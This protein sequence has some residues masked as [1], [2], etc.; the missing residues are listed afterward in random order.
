MTALV[1]VAGLFATGMAAWSV[2]GFVDRAETVEASTAAEHATAAVRLVLDRAAAMVR[3]VR[4]MYATGEVTDDQF[5]RFARTLTANQGVAALGFI[6]RIDDKDRAQYETRL[7]SSPAAALGVWQLGDNGTP[8]QAPQRPSYLVLEANLTLSGPPPAL[9]FD[10]ESLPDRASD[11]HRALQRFQLTTTDEITLPALNEVGITLYDPAVD[12]DSRPIGVAAGSIS[13]RAIIKAAVEASGVAD[14]GIS[15]GPAGGA[16]RDAAGTPTVGTVGAASRMFTFADRLLTVSV[17][18]PSS[19][20]FRPW[21]VLLVAGLGLTTTAAVMAALFNRAKTQE[22]H[23]AEGR[24][25]AMLDGLGPIALLLAAD[26]TVVNAN[27]AAVATFRRSEEDMARHPFEELLAGGDEDDRKRLHTAIAAATRG[28]D[29]RFDMKLDSPE[30]R[31]VFD[32]WIRR[33]ELTGN[34]VASAVDVTDRYEAEETQR[35]LMR[36]LDHRMKNTLQVIQAIIRRTATSQETI[37][38]FEH[39]LLGRIGAMSRAH[40]LL[41]AERWHGA[42]MAAVVRQETEHLGAGKAVTAGG[43]Q[44]RLTPKAALSLALVIHELGTNALKHGAL[45][46]PAGTVDVSWDVTDSPGEPQLVLRWLEFGRSERRTLDTPRLRLAPDRAEHRLRARRVG[47][48][49]LPPGGCRLRHQGTAAHGSVRAVAAAR[50]HV[51]RAMTGEPVLIVE[52]EFIIADEIASIVT[53][54]GYGVVGPVGSVEAA[55]RGLGPRSAAG[56]RRGGCQSPRRI[57]CPGRAA[58]ARNGRAVLRLHRLPVQRSE[59]D[60]WRR[61]AHPETGRWPDADRGHPRRPCG[62]QAIAGRRVRVLRPPP[63]S[64]LDPGVGRVRVVRPALRARLAVE[65]QGLADHRRDHRRIERLGDQEGRLGPLAGEVPLGIG[66][67]EDDRHLKLLQKLVDRIETRAVM[68]ASLMSARI[69]PGCCSAA[70]S[71]PRCACGRCR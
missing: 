14:I 36:E 67:D 46:V 65:E 19:P 47:G 44:L 6:R 7:A 17:G 39:A 41:A 10:A 13:R 42:D 31:Q 2:G 45:S 48:S 60:V 29:V 52:D 66:G 23:V 56:I 71:P 5:Q 11:M 38:K 18:A 30:G 55:E 70:I 33:K 9:G 27:H 51:G 4:A 1:L 32:L 3:A 40:D 63:A 58:A 16:D 22:L 53:D 50:K 61:R 49:R 34:L 62:R 15:I 68:S 57:E 69:R 59:A 25:R 28:V 64:L 24:L 35:L 54:A 37:A 8:V 20:S 12:R 26:G 43:P 21:I